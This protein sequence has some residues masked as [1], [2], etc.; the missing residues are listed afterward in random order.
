MTSSCDA[1]VLFGATGDLAKKKI[2]PALYDLATEGKLPD[3]VVGVALSDWD[4]DRLRQ[5]AR[6]SIE[7]FGPSDVVDDPLGQV[8]DALSYVKGD[9][10]ES[11][12]Y[13]DLQEQLATAERPLMY[14]AIPPSLFTTVIEGLVDAGLNRDGRIVIEKPFGQDLQSAKKL[15]EFVL[16]AFPEERVHRIDHFLGKEQVLDLLVFRLANTVLAPAWN[17]HYIDSVQITMAEDFGVDGRGAFYDETGALKDVVQNH[18]MQVLAQV[19]MEPPVAADAQSL[20]DE[21]VK[22][23]RSLTPLDPDDVVRGQFV[24]YRD[25]EGVAADSDVETFI[26]LKA[27]I[28]SERWAGVPFFI[29]TGKRMPVTAT[30]VLVEFKRPPRL[31]FA[32][33]GAADPHPNHLLFRLNPGE[34]VSLSVEIKQPGDQ[35]ISR[36]VE[37]DYDYDQ[38]RDGPLEEA[39]ARLLEDALEGEQRLFARADGVQQA[40]RVVQPILDN[41][42]PVQGYEPGTWGPSQADELIA[43]HGG[44]HRPKVVSQQG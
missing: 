18:L 23:L 25:E 5:Y 22:V 34:R 7:E 41:P 39:Y 3:T 32:Q 8:L 1:I 38:Q 42:P 15:N 35:L 24:G 4:T 37:L 19:A 12:T 20:R 36:P 13:T 26:A 21:K 43:D 6:E 44:W 30:D 11:S 31:F 2:F 40:W 33:P 27:H 9:Y 10:R 28:E 14:L 17:R 16:D 29:M